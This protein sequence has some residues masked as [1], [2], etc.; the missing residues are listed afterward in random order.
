[1]IGMA[2]AV[3]QG[4]R[5][6]DFSYVT[7]LLHFDGNFSDVIGSNVWVSGATAGEVIDTTHKVFGSG[8]MLTSDPAR[9]SRMGRKGPASVGNL[10]AGAFAIEGRVRFT[11]NND[12]VLVDKY[13]SGNASSYELYQYAGNGML[14]FYKGNG[15]EIKGSWPS[16]PRDGNFHAFAVTRELD[17]PSGNYIIRLFADG[18]LIAS[19][20]D[21]TNFTNANLTGLAHQIGG[22]SGYTLNGN[23][24]EVRFTVGKSRRIAA[25]TPDTKPFPSR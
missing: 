16:S 8:S 13:T 22:S 25:Y 9:N 21:N 7:G 24:E 6:P 12:A 1:M 19:G 18:A 15:S 4:S 20:V 17:V 5:D 23:L 10:G 3:I 2:G 14:S 11:D